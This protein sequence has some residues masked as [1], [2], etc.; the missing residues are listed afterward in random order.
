MGGQNFFP[1]FDQRSLTVGPHVTETPGVL[2]RSC[3]LLHRKPITETTSI[4]REEVF[5]Q[6]A[7]TEKANQSQTHLLDQ[8]HFSS[9]VLISALLD[10]H[11][12]LV[13]FWEIKFGTLNFIIYL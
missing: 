4:A 1:F 10:Q 2:S 6:E 7:R 12:S 9:L 5:N 3:C 11:E 8:L 13:L